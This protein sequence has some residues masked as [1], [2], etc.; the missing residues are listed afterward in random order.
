[1]NVLLTGSNGQLGRCFQDRLP[2]GWQVWATDTA[3]LDITDYAKVL[4]AVKEYQP[5]AIVNAAAYTAVDK[6][7]SEPELAA[8]VNKTGP[9][10][11]A[12]AAKEVGARLVHVSTDYVFDGT[13]TVPYVETD[14][15]NPLGVYGQTKLDGEI[16]VS[17]VLPDAIIIRTAWVFSEY[18]NNF[19]K[20][21]LRLAKERD[22]L[23]IVSDQRGC[24]TYAGDIAQAIIDLL[25]KEAEAGIYHYCGDNEVAWSD[26]AEV[27]F[28][29]ALILDKLDKAP[30]IKAITTDQYPTPA[31]RPMYSSLSC[32][33]IKNKGVYASEWHSR[34]V[35]IIMKF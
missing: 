27:I 30:V 14:K 15:T 22:E 32:I 3:E 4:A 33:K 9:E 19:V 10:N 7:E 29:T 21:M 12:R 34:L 5:D 13:A 20:T 1:M 16:A 28:D 31:K 26:F 17:T 6:A 25:E 2:A 23:S 8:L 11:L 18:G 24:P 35:D